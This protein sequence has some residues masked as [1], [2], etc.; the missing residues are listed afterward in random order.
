VTA[1]GVA[2]AHPDHTRDGHPLR[3]PSAAHVA[4]IR[5][6][7]AQLEAD[8]RPHLQRLADSPRLLD[9]TRL[10]QVSA[11][12]GAALQ[13]A[14]VLATLPPAN[15]APPPLAIVPPARRTAGPV[16]DP[17]GEDLAG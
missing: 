16:A 2:V 4:A 15:S 9:P 8:L 17:V 3:S 5:A 13:A 11:L 1:T 14:E 7:A 6:R 10:R 12:L